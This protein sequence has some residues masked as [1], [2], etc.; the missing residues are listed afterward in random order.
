MGDLPQPWRFGI[1]FLFLIFPIAVVLP[2][3]W[4]I[5][6]KAGF[7]SILSLLI[8]IPLVNF[9]FFCGVAFSRWKVTPSPEP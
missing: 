7:P 9:V 5:F 2:L 1:S 3:F 4:T 6:K 8:L